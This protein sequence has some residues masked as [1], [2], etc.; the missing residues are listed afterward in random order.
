MG[1]SPAKE[2]E[3]QVNYRSQQQ[4]EDARSNTHLRSGA[5]SAGKDSLTRAWHGLHVL[6]LFLQLL[7][8]DPVS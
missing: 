7:L 8:F 4:G 2:S 5:S 3:P 1:A 6:E